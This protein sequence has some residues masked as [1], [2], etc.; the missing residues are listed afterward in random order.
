M[1]KVR[2]CFP[3]HWLLIGSMLMELKSQHQGKAIVCFSKQR[4]PSEE[5]MGISSST[6]GPKAREY[7]PAA[8]EQKPLFA[9]ANDELRTKSVHGGEE[10][11]FGA[12]SKA[13]LRESERWRAPPVLSTV[14]I[15]VICIGN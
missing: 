4:A 6:A 5:G 10:R 14:H 8:D 3:M 1:V 13:T 11:N 2:D 15:I 12:R 7:R 9:L